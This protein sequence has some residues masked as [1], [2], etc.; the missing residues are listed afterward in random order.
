MNLNEKVYRT[1][2]RLNKGQW[3]GEDFCV[4]LVENLYKVGCNEH[5]IEIIGKKYVQEATI[6]INKLNYNRFSSQRK[7]RWINELE[8]HYFLT[9]I[10]KFPI[11]DSTSEFLESDSDI[12]EY[13]SYHILHSK[14]I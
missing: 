14:A 13:L 6:F 11:E 12:K 7:E 3:L 5:E 1:L 9:L 2:K 8:D 4:K 10:H